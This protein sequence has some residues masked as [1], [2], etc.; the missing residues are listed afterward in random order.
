MTPKRTFRA[1]GRAC[2]AA[3]PAALALM[4]LALLAS[5]PLA[6]QQ[7]A[8]RLTARLDREAGDFVLSL[9][10]VDLPAGATHHQV[11]QPKAQEVPLPGAGWLRGYRVELVDRSG[12][13]VPQAVLHHLN[14]MTPGRREMFS[15]IMLRLGAAGHETAPV[16]LPFLMGFKVKEGEKILVT[17]MFSNEES[18][19][20]YQGV[21]LRVHLPFTPDGTWLPPFSVYPFYIDVMPPAGTHAYDLPPGKSQRSWDAH[22]AAEARIL[23]VGGHL[24]KYGTLLR[25][26]DAT[27]RKVLWEARPQLG[28]DSDVVGM[29]VGRFWW[30]GG[31]KVQPGHVYRVTAFYDNPTGRTIPE[32]AMGTFG[33]ILVPSRGAVWPA[34]D[35]SDPEYRKDVLVT[36]AGMQMTGAGMDMHMP[37]MNPRPA[38]APAAAKKAP[39]PAA[40]TSARARR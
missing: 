37:G 17:A 31:V 33:G 11:L 20:A 14:L 24:H 39:A 23:G 40:G 19:Q 26:E 34:L 7:S 36:W 21:T 38:A 30:R 35:T 32:G 29:P 15:P 16:K 25:F 12:R 27:A 5:A 4:A 10:P 13:P 2:P 22:P 18:R 6:A 28:A 3:G 8:A 1:G 9:G